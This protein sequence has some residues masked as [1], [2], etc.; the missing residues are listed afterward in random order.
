M[1]AKGGG[2]GLPAP[3]GERG[4]RGPRPR[5]RARQTQK[6]S[7]WASKHENRL[8]CR[9][10]RHVVG[11]AA[12][13]INIA[14]RL[15]AGS[16]CKTPALS[17]AADP[18]LS[19]TADPPS[20][21]RTS[22]FGSSSECPNAR[23]SGYPGA[24]LGRP[25]GACS[26]GALVRRD[27]RLCQIG[28]RGARAACAPHW[29][30]GILALAPR[31]RTEAAAS[32]GAALAEQT[33]HGIETS[34]RGGVVEQ[35]AAG[36]ELRPAGRVVSSKRDCPVILSSQKTPWARRSHGVASRWGRIPAAS[37]LAASQCRAWDCTSACPLPCTTA[38]DDTEP[39]RLASLCVVTGTRITLG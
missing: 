10:S 19:G 12:S 24:R 29:I 30:W 2:C 8:R 35:R 18:P 5:P 9:N 3:A 17:S 14:S 28:D 1:H 22:T 23:A 13:G 26:E 16:D 27:R 21:K 39:A 6:T 31:T 7:Y 4:P 36:D 20:N 25:V 33:S 32:A 11:E 34:T 37:Y 38:R 15:S